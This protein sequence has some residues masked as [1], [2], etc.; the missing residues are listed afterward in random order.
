MRKTTKFSEIA[1]KSKGLVDSEGLQMLLS[2]GMGSAVRIAKDAN[3]CVRIGRRVFYNVE[4][5]QKYL[6][7]IS[8][9]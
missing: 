6:N 7:E 1:P 8:G 3:A 2:C 9:E 4:K 5:I